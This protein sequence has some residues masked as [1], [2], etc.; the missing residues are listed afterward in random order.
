ML[1]LHSIKRS[2][3]KIG[4]SR[5]G[6][7]DE[8]D[9]SLHSAGEESADAL[10]LGAFDGSEHHTG[11]AVDDAHQQASAALR[12]ILAQIGG[13]PQQTLSAGLLIVLV[14]SEE[15]QAFAQRSGDPGRGTGHSAHGVT[16]QAART[17]RQSFHEFAWT[18][19][20]TFKHVN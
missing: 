19:D 4:D 10:L 5:R 16:E 20:G 12:Q 14:E 1:L 8:A 6:P 18:L 13:T 17:Q 2:T 15:R 3:G 11:D 7:G 9:D